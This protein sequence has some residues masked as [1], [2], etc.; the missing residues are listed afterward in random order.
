MSGRA[1][2]L[3]ELR[4]A[5]CGQC[6]RAL[7]LVEVGPICGSCDCVAARE[8]DWYERAI[9]GRAGPPLRI[10]KRSHPQG[11]CVIHARSELAVFTRGADQAM[12]RSVL[13]LLASSPVDWTL[14][15]REVYR[16]NRG[17]LGNVQAGVVQAVS[18]QN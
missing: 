14:P 16:R 8:A 15:S 9:Q 3:R 11:W 18:Q 10:E 4:P 7:S 5:V 1:F 2:D 13:E 12:A 17:L 6:F